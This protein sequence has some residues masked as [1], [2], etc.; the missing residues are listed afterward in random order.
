MNLVWVDMEMIGLD[1]DKDCII[2]VVVV[3][4]DVE[5]NVLGEGLVLVI[6]QFDELLDGM[7][8]WNKGIYGCFG[9]IDCVKVFIVIEVDVEQ[10]II[11]FLK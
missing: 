8:V 1:L 7:D 6:Y 3:V 10:Q 2:E 4:I 11:V 9:L 5:L